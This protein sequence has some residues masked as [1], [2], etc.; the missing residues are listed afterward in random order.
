MVNLEKKSVEIQ[1]RMHDSV[2]QTFDRVSSLNDNG[3][4]PLQG[5]QDEQP[6]GVTIPGND[7]DVV[8]T[9]TLYPPWSPDTRHK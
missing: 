8:D 3:L 2:T 4:T 7:N 5:Q 1:N 9:M 6:E